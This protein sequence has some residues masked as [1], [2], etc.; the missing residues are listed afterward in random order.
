MSAPGRSPTTDELRADL[1]ARWKAAF[2]RIAEVDARPQGAVDTVYTQVPAFALAGYSAKKF[3]PGA[4]LAREPSR[5]GD[6]YTFRLD[7]RGR[8]LHVK[9]AHRVNRVSWKGVYHYRPDEIEYLE[10]CMQTKVP[11]V[12]NRLLLAGDAVLAEQR[13]VCNG[14]GSSEQLA[15]LSTRKKIADILS[16]PHNYFVYVTLYRLEDGVTTAGE[17]LQEV[18]GEIHR[19]TLAYTYAP[20]GKLQRIVQQWEGGERRTV[21]AARSK[22]TTGDLSAALSARIAEQVLT[23]LRSAGLPAPLVA[24]ELS[25]RDDDHPIPQLIPLTERDQ[26]DGLA[27]AAEIPAERWIA[28]DE[29]DF[30][31][32]ITE[33]VQRARDTGDHAAIPSMLRAAARRV[34]E[35]APR[36]VPVADGFVAFAIDWELEGDEIAKIL[37]QCGAS[38]ERIRAWKKMGWC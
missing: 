4:R 26:V 24:L 12:Y 10:F 35:D 31:P 5:D 23:R 20:D 21:F 7:A 1:I 19:P 22:T 18:G 6:D 13:F 37:K 25:Y 15:K 17:E 32:E 8:P 2:D 14:G 27:L 29:E 36:Q 30:A 28:L 11:S 33:L 3:K 38:A 9:F 34:T 16:D